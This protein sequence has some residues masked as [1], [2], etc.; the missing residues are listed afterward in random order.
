MLSTQQALTGNTVYGGTTQAP[1]Q[2]QV[3]AQGAQG[4]IKRE[5]R[6][7][8]RHGVLRRIGNDGQSDNRSTVA[9]QALH[10]QVRFNGGR[11]VVNNQTPGTHPANA[12]GAEQ[13]QAPVGPPPIKVTRDGILQLPYD[14]SFSAEQLAAITDANNQL[15]ELNN[16]TNQHALDHAANRRNAD[17]A[18]EQLRRQAL[19]GNAASGTAFSSRY[20]TEV[21]NNATDYAH[22]VS[23]LDY[24]NASF[25]QN[26]QL[27]QA[28]IE[29]SLNQQLAALAQDYSNTLNDQAGQLGFGTGSPQQPLNL[30]SVGTGHLGLGHI[31]GG[32]K[33]HHK[34]PRHGGTK[35][36]R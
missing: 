6:H 24:E 35:P 2:G 14:Q 19:S 16:E 11:P 26:R 27:Q 7:K 28:A 32:K 33:K 29:S 8:K 31:G 34:P 12:V 4:Y 17:A 21:A 22:E 9:A 1:N 20:G 13:S 23:D 30:P 10:R 36:S 25:E 3:S 18:Y 15:L 5:L